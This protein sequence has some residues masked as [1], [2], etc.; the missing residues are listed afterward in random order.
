MYMS[1]QLKI[2]SCFSADSTTE[3]ENEMLYVLLSFM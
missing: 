1:P 3:E 2:E